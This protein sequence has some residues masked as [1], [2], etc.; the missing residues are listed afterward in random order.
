MQVVTCVRRCRDGK[1]AKRYF[2]GDTD[3]IDPMDP[4]A[5]YFDGW[6]DGTEVYHEIKGNKLRDKQI[7]TR[8]VG[9]VA[10]KIPAPE[11]PA[12]EVVEQ[13]AEEDTMCPD[14]GKGP[15]KNI[16]A[17]KQHCKG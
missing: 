6:A 17:H 13:V 12:P 10:A 2:P 16:G 3:N 7:T 5:M 9:K 1:T 4:I 15:F 11:S 8:I 14:C